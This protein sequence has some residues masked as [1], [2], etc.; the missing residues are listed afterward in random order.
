MTA[1]K[2]YKTVEPRAACN[3]GEHTF[4]VTSSVISAASQKATHVM[5]QHC[6]ELVDLVRLSN[7]R[8]AQK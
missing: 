4:I 1:K 6:L 8:L 7:E 3:K 5:C 2:I